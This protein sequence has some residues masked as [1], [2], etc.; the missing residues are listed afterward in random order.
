MGRRNEEVMLFDAGLFN[1]DLGAEVALRLHSKTLDPVVGVGYPVM[2]GGIGRFRVSLSEGA[3]WGSWDVAP[4]I[5]PGKPFWVEINFVISPQGYRAKV[6]MEIDVLRDKA[7]Q[8][9]HTALSAD[10]MPETIAFESYMGAY[11]YKFSAGVPDM[12][13]WSLYVELWGQYL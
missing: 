5:V 1:F 8:W 11:W 2:S 6:W 12:G 9:H 4:E 13:N 10:I 3:S 7:V